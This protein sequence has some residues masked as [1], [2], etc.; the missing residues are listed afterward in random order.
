MGDS[1]SY[2]DNLLLQDILTSHGYV[3][4][5]ACDNASPYHRQLNR[6]SSAFQDFVNVFIVVVSET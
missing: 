5:F 6:L 3:T 2:L 4:F 1:I